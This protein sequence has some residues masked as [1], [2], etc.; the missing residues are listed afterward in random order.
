MGKT[1]RR[2]IER[3]PSSPST[4]S[5]YLYKN[6][7]TTTET[8][9]HL[10]AR[11]TLWSHYNDIHSAT[12]LSQI[13][14]VENKTFST[15]AAPLL[16]GSPSSSSSQTTSEATQ[17]P[18]T[19]TYKAFTTAYK[20]TT[21]EYIN[22]T[23]RSS[24]TLTEL[25]RLRMREEFYATYDVMTGIRIAATLGGF[26]LLMVFLIVYKSRS[27]SIRAL[28][29]PKIAARAAAAVQE[30]EDREMQEV[31]E[32]TAFSLYQDE[33]ELPPMPIDFGLNR[34]RIASVGNVSC[35]PY[36]IN[37]NLRFSSIGGY[38]ALLEPPRRYSASGRNRRQNSTESSRILSAYHL[39]DNYS[40]QNENFFN[41]S[42]C[43]EGDDEFDQRFSTTTAEIASYP[44]GL[45]S[46]PRGSDSRRSSGMTC[47]STESSF[48]ERRCSA[49]TLGLNSLPPV[50]R[51][52]SRRTSRDYDYQ[53]SSAYPGI[54]IIEATPKSSPCPSERQS[55]LSVGCGSSNSNIKEH[56]KVL[57][58]F[59]RRRHEDNSIDSISEYPD[60]VNN[61]H[62]FH[63]QQ[64]YQCSDSMR[65]SDNVIN[66]NSNTHQSKMLMSSNN[67]N[68]NHKLEED[69]DDISHQQQQIQQQKATTT[70]TENKRAPLASLSSFKMSSI[71]C[72]DSTDANGS[73]FDESC[74][75]TDDDLAQFSTDSD[76]IS[77]QSPPSTD[78]HVPSGSSTLKCDNSVILRSNNDITCM[79]GSP[80]SHDEKERER[81]SLSPKDQ[82]IERQQRSNDKLSTTIRYDRNINKTNNNNNNNVHKKS[83]SSECVAI[84]VIDYKNENSS[85][86]PSALQPS[87]STVILEMPELKQQQQQVK[88]SD[89][90]I[91]DKSLQLQEQQQIFETFDDPSIPGPSSRKWSK[92]TLF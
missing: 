63:H 24:E 16:S 4:S 39:N 37:P 69:E 41:E 74:A 50:S 22:Y 40:N 38:S 72:Q 27:H 71:E 86:K 17:K 23:N 80:L 53:L 52:S 33:L 77:L 19:T 55:H 82:I 30:E 73:V 7:E 20:S 88:Q 51:A 84:T 15:A 31:F 34:D 90:I 5:A 89:E 45:L 9:S 11:S 92:E 46:V 1:A 2:S 29:D 35:P 14:N 81:I 91:M 21:R 57:D 44:H 25:D 26:F 68:N 48:L 65:L 64:Q 61:N 85:I 75:D 70:D 60:E 56:I 47:C 32:K 18:P 42:D 8:S 67:S 54:H 6:E 58:R 10:K 3:S 66:S 76:E 43:E 36:L 13:K 12:A 62:Q 28:K 78:Q 49:I 87:S 83:N 59:K 79:R